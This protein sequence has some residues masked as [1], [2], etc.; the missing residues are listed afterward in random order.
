[1]KN[2]FAKKCEQRLVKISRSSIKGLPRDVAAIETWIKRLGGKRPG[3][4][5]RARL[6]RLGLL[7]MPQE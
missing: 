3:P 6:R 2:T 7:G 1:M 5:E 4:K